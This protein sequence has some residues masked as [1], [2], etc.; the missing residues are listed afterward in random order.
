MAGCG[1]E[2][3]SSA[4]TAVGLLGDSDE[5]GVCWADVDGDGIF[6]TINPKGSGPQ[7]SFTIEDTMGCSCAQIIQTLGLG[8][9]HKK[10]G[11][12]IFAMQ[13]WIALN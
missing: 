11:C 5:G 10:Y 3:L 9:G 12:S 8:E 2:R 7:L 13:D 6:E 4:R 1:V